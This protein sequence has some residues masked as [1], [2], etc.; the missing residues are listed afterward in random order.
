MSCYFPID[1][2]PPRGSEILVTKAE[3][4]EG[5]RNSLSHSGIFAPLAMPLFMEKLDSDL[6][7]AKI[8]N[9]NT[10]GKFKK[11][12]CYSISREFIPQ[13]CYFYSFRAPGL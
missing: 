2:S 4:I 6:N 13:S 8:G 5:L 3:L 12:F 10:L 11:Y 9:Y 7:D 1:F